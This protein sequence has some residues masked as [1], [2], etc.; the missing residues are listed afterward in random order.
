M[1]D[2]PDYGFS[3]GKPIEVGGFNSVG[4]Q[5]QYEFMSNLRGPNGERLSMHRVGSCCG[6]RTKNGINGIGLL[7]VW[8]V[9]MPDG[10]LRTLFISSYDLREPRV[11]VGFTYLGLPERVHG[12]EMKPSINTTILRQIEEVALEDGISEAEAKVLAQYTML[13]SGRSVSHDLS[14]PLVMD[15]SGIYFVGFRKRGNEDTPFD[16]NIA[17]FLSSGGAVFMITQDGTVSEW[18]RGDD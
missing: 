8:E 13:E 2:D 6:F 17:E 14:T 12:N 5:Y 15:T 11:P 4:H 10:S 16:T 7:D 9:T 1:A 18:R 3:E